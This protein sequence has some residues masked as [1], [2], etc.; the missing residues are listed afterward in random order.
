MFILPNYKK[1]SLKIEMYLINKS[2]NLKVNKRDYIVK[3]IFQQMTKL[4][5]YQKEVLVDL[6]NLLLN[7]S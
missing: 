5:I 1:L 6:N 2:L 7:N 3:K 4:L